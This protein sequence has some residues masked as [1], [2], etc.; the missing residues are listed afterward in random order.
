MYVYAI[1][2]YVMLVQAYPAYQGHQMMSVAPPG[3]PA[4]QVKNRL[5]VYVTRPTD[6][7]SV[8]SLKY[9]FSF[10]YK[11]IWL[12]GNSIF[13][14]ENHLNLSSGPLTFSSSLGHCYKFGFPF[15]RSTSM[16]VIHLQWLILPSSQHQV[17]D[18]H[19][20]LQHSRPHKVQHRRS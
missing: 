2:L 1:I 7:F 16:E 14:I 11:T 13:A 20:I 15:C 19:H 17:E 4:A 10:D 3:M 18:N 5:N 6:I 8:K 12:H 9:N